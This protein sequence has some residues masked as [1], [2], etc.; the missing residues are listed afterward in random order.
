MQ[1]RLPARIREAIRASVQPVHGL[2]PTPF[3][4]RTARSKPSRV[5]YKRLILVATA[6]ALGGAIAYETHTSR[7]QSRIFSSLSEKITFQMASGPSDSVPVAP[8]GPYDQRLGY[9]RAPNL[10]D[11][12]QQAGFSI[13]SQAR[14][15]VELLDWSKK[16][17]FPVYREKTQAG[18]QLKDAA[19]DKIFAA[20]YPERTYDSFDEIPKLVV[21]SLRFI[22][23]R[24]ILNPDRPR[25]N[26]AVEWDRFTRAVFDLGL[27]RVMPSHSRTGGSTLAT[28]LEKLRHSDG[29]LT[30]G[31][32]DKVRQMATAS[33]RSYLDGEQTLEAQK[34]VLL[35]YVNS[36]PLSGIA[37]YGEVRGLGDGLWAWFDAD[38]DEVNSLLRSDSADVDERARAYRQTLS[39]L[40]ALNRPTQFLVSDYP[41]LDKRAT[42]FL[43]LLERQGVITAE[44]RDAAFDVE[45]KPRRAAD[46]PPPESFV[47][48]KAVNAVRASLLNV[49]DT[50]SVYDLDRLDL[51][52]GTSLDGDSQARAS[53]ELED[54]LDGDHARQA[55]LMG[56]RLLGQADASKLVYSFNLYERGSTANYLRVQADNWNQPLNINE[57]TKLELGSTAKLRTL[58]SYLQLVRSLHDQ[59]AHWPD[60]KLKKAR[61]PADDRLGSW[62]VFHLLTAQDKTLDTMLESA[63]N[64]HY[65]ASPRESFFTGG[66]MHRFSNFTARD[67][68][69]SLT[70][71]EAFKRSVNLV[72]IRMMRD[73]VGYH[74]Y[75]GPK[76]SPGVLTNRQD[77][78]RERYLVRFAEEEGKNFLAS[79]YRVHKELTPAESIAKLVSRS[80]PTSSRLAAIHRSLWPDSE[81]ADLINF[82]RHHLPDSKISDEK[83]ATLYDQNGRDRLDLQDRA[84][85]AKVHPLE[86]WL[87]DFLTQHPEAGWNEV[88][89]ASWDARQNAYRWLWRTRHT[90]A[91]DRRIRI[92]LEMEAF[93]EIHR[94]WSRL[95]YPFSSLVPSYASAIGSSGDRPDAL[96]ELVGIVLNDGVRNPTVRITDL[97]FGEDTPYETR[98]ER[99][100]DAGVRVMH[101]SVARLLRQEL[102]NVVDGGTAVRARGSV[103]LTDGT[104]V[105]VGGKTGT[106][107]NRFEVFNARGQV[108]ETHTINRTATFVFTIGDSFYGVVTAYVDGPE[109]AKYRFTS[110][111]PVQVF[112]NLVATVQPLIEARLAKGSSGGPV[113]PRLAAA[114]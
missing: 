98:L 113:A 67:N 6:C 10:L 114:P 76:A 17:V 54:L 97:H 85:V 60:Q 71:R 40:L 18:L 55:G 100:Q 39:L 36:I 31:V 101:S 64:R 25:K 42:G 20:R 72:F 53:R 96:A 80:A 106:G 15:S 88:V 110:S 84:Y 104:V 102:V 69:R 108:L 12:L 21:D 24:E 34:R 94:S 79:F 70:V 45:I 57:G 50:D 82:V 109:A 95:G 56:F 89:K 43:P 11:R 4:F 29:G 107:D 65:S 16:G 99:E 112:K 9:S 27:N 48:R 1:V 61:P 19:G 63:M 28:Q 44:L 26:P 5:R 13:Q 37:E 2:V 91:Q 62:A 49:L 14:S 38:F 83:L 23:N 51:T 3:L 66:G 33:L 86:L 75:N 35:N 78:R 93:D 81:F 59:Y 103:I 90:I 58:V 73:I 92:V 74:L 7:L 22:E 77:P 30:A 46:P 41:A 105:E 47:E 8:A 52:V 87:V 68:T 32:S 111:L